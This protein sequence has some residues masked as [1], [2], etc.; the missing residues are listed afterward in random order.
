M[1]C[2]SATS[3]FYPRDFYSER[4]KYFFT[5]TEFNRLGKFD[6]S[7]VVWEGKRIPVRMNDMFSCGNDNTVGFVVQGEVVSSSIDFPSAI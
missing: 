3:V 4:R 6:E 5:I 7:N 2:F 1:P